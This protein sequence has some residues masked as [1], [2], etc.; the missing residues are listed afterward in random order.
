MQIVTRTYYLPRNK[1][2]R[3]LMYYIAKQTACSIGKIYIVN[4]TIAFPI[5]L[6]KQNIIQV[7]NI[8]QRYDLL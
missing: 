4:D 6:P 8:L 2:G 3:L 5:T 7:E 1:L